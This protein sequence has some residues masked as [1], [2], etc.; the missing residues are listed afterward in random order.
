MNSSDLQTG[1][2]VR[3]LKRD[4][5][6]AMIAVS[7]L[8]SACRNE[9]ATIEGSVFI[10]SRA[11]ENFKLALV[12]VSAFPDSIIREHLV[13][14]VPQADSSLRELVPRARRLLES[15]QSAEADLHDAERLLS[16]PLSRDMWR[17]AQQT[18][19]GA[20]SGTGAEDVVEEITLDE[21]VARRRR[22]ATSARS[23]LKAVKDS[24]DD[25]ADGSVFVKQLPVPLM[26]TKTDADG[27]FTMRLPVG[28]TALLATARR[29]LGPITEKYVWI[30]WI[31]LI[32][33]EV[34][35]IMLS[36]DNLFSTQCKQCYPG[37]TLA[38]S[39]T[40]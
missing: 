6:C 24:L 13:Q 27:R 7:A 11:G 17:I 30:V 38:D 16:Q 19:R 23:R 35:K 1:K 21:H 32:Q 36:N 3:G 25:I 18:L 2:S 20:L 39:S 40:K 14:L 29:E 22:S 15:F 8:L 26:T 5:V 9:S 28:R 10:A 12:E 37:P 31:D 33:G 4:L 34:A